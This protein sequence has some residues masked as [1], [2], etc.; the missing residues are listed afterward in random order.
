MLVLI[1]AV[2][3]FSFWWLCVQ[4]IGVASKPAL[5]QTVNVVSERGSHAGTQAAG[6]EVKKESAPT[7]SKVSPTRPSS[8]LHPQFDSAQQ[9]TIK[10]N[11]L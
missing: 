7:F 11:C 2:P 3:G 10:W 5:V 1:F 4:V 9:E 6:V 8:H